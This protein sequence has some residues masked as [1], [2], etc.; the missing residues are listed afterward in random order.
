MPAIGGGPAKLG[1]GGLSVDADARLDSGSLSEHGG[2]IRGRG[3]G[4]EHLTNRGLRHCREVAG[5][6]KHTTVGGFQ[7]GNDSAEGPDSRETIREDQVGP[8]GH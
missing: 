5:E 8:G 7:R 6:H 2:C 3:S 4:V 1:Q